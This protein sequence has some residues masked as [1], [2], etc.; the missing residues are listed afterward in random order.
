MGAE[1]W[2][3]HVERWRASGLTQAQYSA[4]QRINRHTL[5]HWSWRLQR[6]ASKDSAPT[7][8]PLR[9]VGPVATDEA[10]ELRCGEWRLRLPRDVGAEWV[11]AL[12]RAVA[13]C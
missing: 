3:R 1:Q 6:D 8:I 5:A 7:L 2:K 4:R 11:A 12:L 9:V 10:I 13:A